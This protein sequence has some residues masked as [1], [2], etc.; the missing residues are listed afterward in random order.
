M[1]GYLIQACFGSLQKTGNSCLKTTGFVT[2]I[3]IYEL[4]KIM[5]G[6]D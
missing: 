4:L 1:A 2:E 6:S 5:F 3:L